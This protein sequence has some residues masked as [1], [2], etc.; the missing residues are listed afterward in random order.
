MTLKSERFEVYNTVFNFMIEHD[1]HSVP[2]KAVEIA[3]L[4]SAELIPLSTLAKRSGLP[5]E[6]IMSILG[7]NDG[8][9][10]A[11]HSQD[12]VVYKI[13]YNDRQSMERIRFTC[14]EECSH[15][16][17]GHT[18]DQRFNIFSQSYEEDIYL[19][20]DELARI[21]AGLF[22]CPPQLFFNYKSYLSTGA[23]MEVCD[24]SEACA[25]ARKGALLRFE[26]EI[27]THPLYSTLP[28]I[29]C[30]KNP[31]IQM[32]HLKPVWGQ[33]GSCGQFQIIP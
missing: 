12:K 16:L 11:Y 13:I 18:E 29:R 6:D 2:V 9:T 26:S 10:C 14:L 15:I 28:T 19:K 7:S 21:A 24:I 30:K 27:K 25:K 22:L 4:L 31:N 1:I 3:N 33:D 32:R 17:L 8:V 20:Y 5:P 23:L